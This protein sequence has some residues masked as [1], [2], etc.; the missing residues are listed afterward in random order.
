MEEEIDLRA[1]VLVLLKYWKWILE[2]TVAAAV[3]ALVVS[4]LLPPTYEATALVAIKAPQYVM[5]FDPRFEV[6]SQLPQPAYKAYPDLAEGDEVLEALFARL[7]PRPAEIETLRD[8]QERVEAKAG[9]DPSVVRLTVRA[10]DP[11]EAA[12]IANLWAELFVAHANRVYGA[13]DEEL[14]QLEGQLAQAQ[15]EL[16][17]AEQALIEFQARNQASILDAR[18]DSLK[19]DQAHYLADQRAI[20][21]ILQDIQALREQLARQPDERPASLADDLTTLFLQIKAFNAQASAPIQLQVNSAEPLSN[22]SIGETMALLDDM[23]GALEAKSAEIGQRLEE[24][25]PQIL[26]L[27]RQLQEIY[28]ESDRLTRQRD[29][30]KETYTALARKVEETRIAVQ[31]AQSTA[32]L[33]SRAAVP[34][35]PASPRKLLNT[36]VAGALGLMLSVFGAFG[37]EWWRS[38][39]EEQRSGGAEG[40]RSGGAEERRSRGAEGRRSR[41][42]E[43]QRGGGAGERRSRESGRHRQMASGGTGERL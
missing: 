29:L 7:N 34:E 26:S 23:A 24:L 32:R 5:Q 16:E 27:Q 28:T 17:A 14:Q 9:T 41:G 35:K 36:A 15:A 3:V 37:V 11:Q 1:Y 13:S 40:R 43:E 12:R 31:G 10:R 25:Q 30:A 42:A 20:T 2:T 33:G 38:G 6:P 22:K 19:S 39:T 18:L 8:L 21:Y 4:F